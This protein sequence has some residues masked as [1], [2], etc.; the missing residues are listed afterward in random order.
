MSA[1]I[2]Y[3]EGRQP[4]PLRFA[5]HMGFPQAVCKIDEAR[6]KVSAAQ[7][8]KGR[9]VRQDITCPP[10][11][12]WSALDNLPPAQADSL[13]SAY[14]LLETEPHRASDLAEA[15]FPAVQ[16]DTGL[17]P[18]LALVIA[19]RGRIHSLSC[20]SRLDV[21]LEFFA[22]K[23]DALE[24]PSV[25]VQHIDT[26][27]F[28]ALVFRDLSNPD[29]AYWAN[30]ALNLL[31]SGGDADLR[32]EG[33]NYLLLYR[34]WNGD[35]L[36]ADILRRQLVPLREQAHSAS[37]RLLCHSMSAMSLRLF[38]ENEGCHYEIDAGLALAQQSGR[39]FWDS[40]L[41]MQGA[42]L[43]LSMA[44]L[45]EAK[46]WLERM[47]LAAQP[48]DYLNRS[49]YHYLYAWYNLVQDEQKFALTH[50]Q[51]SLRL[52]QYSGAP[53]PIAVTHMGLVQVLLEQRQRRQAL[54]HI[55]KARKV[56]RKMPS[57]PAMT[58]ARGLTQAQMCFKL[59]M[60]S[61]G[62]KVLARTL[63]LGCEQH[64]LN[65]PWWRGEPM[66]QL[67]AEALAH[68]IEREYVLWL[69]RQRRL[70]PP[71]GVHDW[72]WPLTVEVLGIPNIRLDGERLELGARQEALLVALAAMGRG[73]Q[74]VDRVQ[75]S[76][77]LWPDAEGDRAERALDT[78]IHRLRKQLGSE[79][80]VLTRPGALA[81]NPRLCR[82]DYRLLYE[83]LQ[84][85]SPEDISVLLKA[86]NQVTTLPERIR[87]LIPAHHLQR[88]LVE[89][90]LD[91][92]KDRS[93]EQTQRHLECLL[94]ATP[95][96]ERAWQLLI[97]SYVQQTLYGAALDAWRRC[98]EV[99]AET[100]GGVSPT[101]RALVEPWLGQDD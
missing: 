35:L 93:D 38:V 58:F 65:F 98:T 90:L 47:E 5:T 29:I 76:D 81:L 74:W 44:N 17:A 92:L 79:H 26:A 30:S 52:A 94:E 33:G 57:N 11:P 86:L 49:G 83:T 96:V 39:H 15:V 36:G 63:A 99:L 50:A 68:D 14:R 8:M 97:R 77:R 54:R 51:E 18:W 1:F 42:F 2:S 6:R 59:D 28:G 70:Q 56:L 73:Q 19:I 13:K 24:A 43:A 37:I 45:I 60:R 9:F 71:E 67:C 87:A 25:L 85:P 61:R 64:Y 53:F 101:T 34:I 100:P 62:L 82:V 22:K 72:Y 66:A 48:E 69:I 41:Y 32:L 23:R 31:H 46:E 91:L 4:S 12:W 16:N 75:L 88:R 95:E 89:S 3:D 21:F 80:M 7:V 55:A 40:H 78:A 20:F 84:N 27:Y 10:E